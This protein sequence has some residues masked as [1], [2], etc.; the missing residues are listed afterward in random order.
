[1]PTGKDIFS[2]SFSSRLRSEESSVLAL[3]LDVLRDDFGRVLLLR[4]QAIL[5]LDRPE[6][7][8]DEKPEVGRLHRAKPG[9]LEQR[10]APLRR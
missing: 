6:G 10:L 8:I 2:P 7:R 4:E 3:V 1:M 5:L 9:V